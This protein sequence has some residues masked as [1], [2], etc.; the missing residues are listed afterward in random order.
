MFVATFAL[1]GVAC[2]AVV[3]G[4]LKK[5]LQI[6]LIKLS[7]EVG[8]L[9]KTTDDLKRKLEEMERKQSEPQS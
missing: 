5:R 1:G 7:D 8:E 2:L 6:Y 4:M 3:L 9:R